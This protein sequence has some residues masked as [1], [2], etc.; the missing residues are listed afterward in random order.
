MVIS[1]SGPADAE[2]HP[3]KAGCVPVAGCLGPLAIAGRPQPLQVSETDHMPR[4]TANRGTI[5]NYPFGLVRGRKVL[6]V[7]PT[8]TQSLLY[9]PE[10][11]GHITRT[12]A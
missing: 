3:K 1:L 2:L 5:P 10:T 6:P 8:T 12:Y 11:I 9:Y 4:I 7:V